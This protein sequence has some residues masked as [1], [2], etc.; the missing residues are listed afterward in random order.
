MDVGGVERS[1]VG[2]DDV[3]GVT[4]VARSSGNALLGPSLDAVRTALSSALW[5]AWSADEA[6]TCTASVGDEALVLAVI[7]CVVWQVCLGQKK[8]K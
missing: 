2:A 4:L 8:S 6:Q 3:D 5:R 7:P 1:R